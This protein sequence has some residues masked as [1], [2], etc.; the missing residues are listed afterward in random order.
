L[1]YIHKIMKGKK[2]NPLPK[3]LVDNVYFWA[4]VLQALS[5]AL[6]VISTV[7]IVVSGNIRDSN[8]KRD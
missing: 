1:V 6:G 8:L 5:L 2:I 4:N 7:V 3:M